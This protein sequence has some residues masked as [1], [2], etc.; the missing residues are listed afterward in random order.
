MP[1]ERI[2]SL[3]FSVLIFLLGAFFAGVA[4]ATR[5]APWVFLMPCPCL[6]QHG[7]PSA[8][9]FEDG[10]FS[11]IHLTLFFLPLGPCPVF[12]GLVWSGNCFGYGMGAER[13]FLPS[14]PGANHAAEFGWGSAPIPLGTFSSGL[15]MGRGR[16]IKL[17]RLPPAPRH[18]PR[19]E[20]PPLPLGRL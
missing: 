7:S 12:G 5:H 20:F 18:R 2:S 6:R 16:Y 19:P 10:I 15:F 4:A 14:S 8:L 3:Y 1:A 17:H 13:P 11:T 9:T